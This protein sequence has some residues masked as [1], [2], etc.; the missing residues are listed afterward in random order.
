MEL[1]EE[2]HIL[3][4]KKVLLRSVHAED[5]AMMVDYLK[6]NVK[7]VLDTIRITGKILKL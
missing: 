4:G 3:N 1:P 7:V 5:A 6:T 2:E